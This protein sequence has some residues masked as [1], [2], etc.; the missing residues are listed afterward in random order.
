M[1]LQE[2][3][4]NLYNVFAKYT[5]NEKIE[6]CPCCV[7]EEDKLAL[8]AK[9]LKRLTNQD[10]LNYAFKAMTTWG[11]EDDYKHFLPRI[12]ELNATGLSYDE[13]LLI[14]KLW[15]GKW[16]TWPS[17]EI[18]A[19]RIFLRAWLIDFL[20]NITFFNSR[21]I[22][23]I[24]SILNEPEIL[25]YWKITAKNE[26]SKPLVDFI[27]SEYHELIRPTYDLLDLTYS[28]RKFF[29]EWIDGKASILEEDFF[30]YEKIDAKYAKKVS[31]ALYIMEQE[32]KSFKG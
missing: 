5:G 26:S 18:D 11:T 3:I 13:D 15:Y 30:Y 22:G 2:S 12:C 25:N 16:L 8:H 23:Q 31:D 21:F 6:G 32:N 28:Q 27:Y 20:E 14:D 7:S 24:I 1:T 10:L 29:I 4:S 9:P 19:I 17:E